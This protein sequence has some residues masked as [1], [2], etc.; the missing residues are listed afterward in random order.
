VDA[1]TPG[2]PSAALFTREVL[3][4]SRSAQ[5]PPRGLDWG[6]DGVREEDSSALRVP[7]L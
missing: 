2:G 3:G 6:L 7:L 1:R 4:Y 5:E